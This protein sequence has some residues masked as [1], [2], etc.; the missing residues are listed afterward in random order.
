MHV[1][2]IDAVAD[3][4]VNYILS[5]VVVEKGCMV[6]GVLLTQSIMMKMI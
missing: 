2:P 4:A 6:C 3:V 1:E 5:V